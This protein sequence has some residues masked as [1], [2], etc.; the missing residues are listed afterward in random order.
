VDVVSAA[1]R[2]NLPDWAVASPERRAHMRRVATL[3][4]EWAEALGLPER[5]RTEWVALGYL[6]DAL[7]DAPVEELRAEVPEPF[8]DL[9]GPLLHGPAAAERLEGAVSPALLAA[10]GYHTVGH[11]SL[12]RAGKALYLADFLEP[13]RDFEIDWRDGLSRRMP[14][15]LDEVLIEVVSARIR[16]LLEGRKPIRAETAAFWSSLVGRR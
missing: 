10:I 15:D 4:G 11:P 8:R 12:D 3:L 13:G 9:P 5:E 7:R 1:A 14:G 2:G 6:H 16:H